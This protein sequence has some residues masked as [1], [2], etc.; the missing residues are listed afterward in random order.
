MLAIE[1]EDCELIAKLAIDPVKRAL[2][3]NLAV[4]LRS[5]AL[6]IQTEIDGTV[7]RGQRIRSMGVA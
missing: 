6:E 3:K 4:R 5:M 7:A 1:A 2:F